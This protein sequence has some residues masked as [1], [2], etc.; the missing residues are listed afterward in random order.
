M[1]RGHV[2]FGEAGI[3]RR[4]KRCLCVA[5]PQGGA[6]VAQALRGAGLHRAI[7][8]RHWVRRFT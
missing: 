4:R 8:R 1:R 5:V 6:E 3:P 7:R 2:G